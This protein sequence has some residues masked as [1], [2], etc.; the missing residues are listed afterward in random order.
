MF[1]KQISVFTPEIMGSLRIIERSEWLARP[2]AREM[3]ALELPATRVII[4]HTAG[5]C[6]TTHVSERKF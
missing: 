4:A 3:N 1:Y 5:E 6:A 2:P